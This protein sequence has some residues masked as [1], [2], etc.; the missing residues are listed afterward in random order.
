MGNSCGTV[1]ASSGDFGSM[2]AIGTRVELDGTH[3][4]PYRTNAS[5][6]EKLLR[7][8]VVAMSRIATHYFPEVLSVIQDLEGDTG[9]PPV[10]PREGAPPLEVATLPLEVSMP[11]LEQVSQPLEVSRK[12][13]RQRIGYSIDMSCD[14]GNSSH[15]DIHDASQG[16]SV[17]TEEQP[18]VAANWYFIMP[19]VH[20]TRLDGPPF[21]GVAIKLRHGTAISWDGRV[22]RHCTSITMPDGI[23]GRSPLDSHRKRD[24]ANHVYGT[25]TAAKE[26]I[27]EAGRRFAAATAASSNSSNSSKSSNERD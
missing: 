15:Y 19:N 26:R 2:Y 9:M 13:R 23:D 16:F 24:F 22:V 27:V 1:R 10:T 14:L 6:P 5:V 12:R 25:F 8:L 4:I 11:P 3:V 20:G 21:A 17:W 18:G 7:K